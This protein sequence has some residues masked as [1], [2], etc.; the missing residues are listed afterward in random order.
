MDKKKAQKALGELLDLSKTL[1]GN[2]SMS[3]QFKTNDGYLWVIIFSEVLPHGNI[4]SGFGQDFDRVI[5]ETRTAVESHKKRYYEVQDMV[6]RKL[7][8]RMAEYGLT[9]KDLAVKIGIAPQTLRFK[10]QGDYEFKADEMFAI[11]RI[12]D[13]PVEELELYFGGE[14]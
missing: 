12:L 8:G 10:L 9:Q 11:K 14:K 13:I 3:I 1:D 2:D 4:T 5:A 6:M 7:V